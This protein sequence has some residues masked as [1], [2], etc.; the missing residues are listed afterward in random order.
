MRFTK[1]FYIKVHICFFMLAVDA[2]PMHAI[3]T[4]IQDFV[5]DTLIKTVQLYP[6]ENRKQ[7]PIILL[8]DGQYLTCRFDRLSDV[9]ENYEYS[10]YACMAD[11]TESPMF[12]Y[13]YIK[14]YHTMPVADYVLSSNTNSRRYVHYWFTFPNKQLAI[15]KS[16]NYVVKVFK[17]GYPDSIILTKR[18]M[19]YEPLTRPEL[20]IQRPMPASYQD[21]HQELS[22][23][24]HMLQYEVMLPVQEIQVTLMQNLRW[25]NAISP[26][27]P[28]LAQ[29]AWLRFHRLGKYLFAAGKEFRQFDMSNMMQRND[30]VLR[31]DLLG[32]DTAY[33]AIDK[34]RKNQS[35]AFF[36]D[37]N[38]RFTISSYPWT[39]ADWE[40]NYVYV[41]FTL[42]TGIKYHNGDIYVVGKFSDWQAKPENKMYFNPETKFYQ[43]IILLKQGYYNYAYAWVKHGT[44]V[45]DLSAIEGDYFETENE[46][47]LFVY[48][49]PPGARYDRLIGYTAVD[50]FGNTRE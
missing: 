30:Q 45:L 32:V 41:V 19:I 47:Q 39:S 35:Y 40:A 9:I 23:S 21:T 15:I 7:N 20:R 29:G 4:I 34:P 10:I 36:P 16:G 28:V 1:S 50:N 38:G 49:R 22:F 46:Y 17:S 27:A 11:W 18:F 25:D 2:T 12:A 43:A 6:G 31:Y 13:E 3:P 48:H 42:N 5:Y 24:V 44:N 8:Q 33:L 14:G 26:I 37:W